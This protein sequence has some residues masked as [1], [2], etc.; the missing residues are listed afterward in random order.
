MIRKHRP[1]VL[2]TNGPTRDLTNNGYIGHPDHQAAGEAALSAVY[3]TARDHLAYPEMLDEGLEPHKVKEVWVMWGGGE[4]NHVVELTEQDVER[5]LSALKAHTSQVPQDV[6]D[7]V[8]EWKARN[9]EPHNV[10][11]AET[12]RLFKLD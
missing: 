2:I 8:L 1:E 5:S 6:D 7:R 11:Y 9:G 3:P 4:A 10:E 12:F